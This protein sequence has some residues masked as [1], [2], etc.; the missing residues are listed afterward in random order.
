MEYFLLQQDKR[1]INTPHLRDIFNKI[2]KKSINLDKCNQIEA[3]L[4]F[5]VDSNKDMNY[6]DLLGGQLFIVSSALMS[7]VAKYEPGMIFKTISLIDFENGR[8]ETYWLPILADVACLA[9][10]SELTIDK[11]FL[12]KIVLQEVAIPDLSIF[13]IAGVATPYIIVRLDLAESI[14]RREFQG[15][16]LTRLEVL[17]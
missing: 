1:Y 5:Q 16:K 17:R 2:N 9:P 14:L 12:K 4:T 15:I 13:R 11:S 6:L 8:K 10:Q 3:E 7:L